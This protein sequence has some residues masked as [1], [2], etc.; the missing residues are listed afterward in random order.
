MSTANTDSAH[1]I[2]AK[3]AKRIIRVRRLHLQN[4]L[5]SPLISL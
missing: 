3:I 2:S 5:T 4:F 1:P